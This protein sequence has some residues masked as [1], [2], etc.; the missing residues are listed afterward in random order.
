VRK[1]KIRI[2]RVERN[3]RETFK[4]PICNHDKTEM[5]LV[6]NWAD[7]DKDLAL[8][9]RPLFKKIVLKVLDFVEED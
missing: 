5:E 8:Y 6:G 7:G 4:E 1:N 2:N 3:M 9:Q